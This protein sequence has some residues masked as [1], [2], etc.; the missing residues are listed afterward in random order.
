MRAAPLPP[1]SL[2]PVLEV[3]SDFNT[4]DQVMVQFTAVRPGESD[5][6]IVVTK[7]DLGPSRDPMIHVVGLASLG[8]FEFASWQRN[9]GGRLGECD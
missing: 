9:E 5:V 6:A 4:N 2:A 8:R 3:T 1:L 7:H